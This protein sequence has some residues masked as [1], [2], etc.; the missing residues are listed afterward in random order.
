MYVIV[1]EFRVEP[2][3][4]E[5]FARLID[6]QAKDSVKLEEGCHRFDVCQDENDPAKFLLYEIYSDKAAFEMH[7]GMGH[8]TRFLAEASPMIVERMIRGFHLR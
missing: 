7:R 1:A 2:P 3:S 6:R 5:A 8:T 4:V